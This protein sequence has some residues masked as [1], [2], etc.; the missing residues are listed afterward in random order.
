MM[1]FFKCFIYSRSPVTVN[2]L[3][4]I[5]YVLATKFKPEDTK[6]DKRVKA[7]YLDVLDTL[8]RSA[9]MII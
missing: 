1:K 8:L 3:L 7:E 6:L 2:W 4:E 9:T 5:L